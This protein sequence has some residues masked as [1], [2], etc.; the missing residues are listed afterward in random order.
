NGLNIVA[1]A[2]LIIFYVFFS[3]LFNNL[4]LKM[5]CKKHQFVY[6][7]AASA[8]IMTMFSAIGY[9]WPSPSIPKLN[10]QVDP[11]RNPLPR[12]TTILE[13]SWITSLM[14][15][16]AL[17][18]PLFSSILANKFGRKRTL[19]MF[20]VP[21]ILSNVIL[22]FANRVVHF[23]IARFL[24]GMGTG[25]VF[26]V[27]P[28]YV[29]EISDIDNRG[30]TS[31]FLALTMTSTQLILYIISPYITISNL[32]V[33]SL[34]PAVLFFLTF[35]FFV[36]ESPYYFVMINRQEEAKKSLAML[37]RVA[38]SDIHLKKE[39]YDI[40]RTVE[41]TRSEKVGL[42]DLLQ[43]DV[44]IRCLL[45]SVGLMVFQ[46]FTGILAIVSYLQTIFEATNSSIPS[47]VS[48]M[49][50]GLL[51]T[52]VNIITSRLV[53]RIGRKTLIMLSNT[54][55]LVSLI[56]LGAYFYLQINGYNVDSL[57]WLA[58]GS[59]M[60]YIFWFNFGIGPIPWTVAGELFP[61][62]LKTYLNGI[63]AFSNII[64]GF[65]ISLLF[66]TLSQIM[67]MAWSIWFFAIWTAV[68]LVFV[69][70]FLPETRGRSF[71]EIQMMLREG[72]T[73]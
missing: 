44:V 27:I 25:C 37:R 19:I 28:L 29:A 32:A 70:Y 57:S 7:A 36:P 46:Q 14:S 30:F 63:T 20:S 61:S 52:I 12:P 31:M 67:G 45:I 69:Y 10:G 15:L 39:L 41:E 72:R 65:L 59:I 3:L 9:A 18:G 68:S 17:V 60:F 1:I 34:I 73:V 23:Y 24:V 54:G 21:M 55:I 49:I 22:I 66:P 5:D 4:L 38:T 11:E 42:R 40:S 6:F 56:T 62:N 35:V 53:D 13:D 50:V 64:C 26:T 48:V 33:V 43:S 2:V 71:I 8:N 16:G 58:I 47:E 51:Q